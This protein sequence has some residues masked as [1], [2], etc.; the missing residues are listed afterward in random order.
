MN[1]KFRFIVLSPFLQRYRLISLSDGM[2][3]FKTLKIDVT[4][5]FKGNCFV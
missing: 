2:T 5:W 3:T 4:D 1:C